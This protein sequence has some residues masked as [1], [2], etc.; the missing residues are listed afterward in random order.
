MEESGPTSLDIFVVHG[1]DTEARAAVEL[2]LTR[3]GFKPIVLSDQPGRGAT[4]IEKLEKYGAPI[5]YA[6]VILTGDDKGRA[7]GDPPRKDQPRARQNVILELGYFLGTLKRHRVAALYEEGVELP[8]D[9]K[10]VEYIP[11]HAAST[12]WKLKLARELKAAGFDVDFN[13]IQ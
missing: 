4:V 9:Y 5:E 3:L 12:E 13:K 7:A 1:H 10:G 8:S 6:V 2:F 11:F